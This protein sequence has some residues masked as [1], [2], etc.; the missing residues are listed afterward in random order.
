MQVVLEI[1]PS[2]PFAH[3]SALRTFIYLQDSAG[4]FPFRPSEVYT[5]VHGVY[6]TFETHL[7]VL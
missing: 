1:E 5:P 6:G 2:F 4:T 7:Q 3:L